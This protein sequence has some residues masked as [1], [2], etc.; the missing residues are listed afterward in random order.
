MI[1][2]TVILTRYSERIQ[3]II[4]GVETLSTIDPGM[5]NVTPV[6]QS[7]KNNDSSNDHDEKNGQGSKYDSEVHGV[8]MQLS[9]K[10]VRGS[11]NCMRLVASYIADAYLAVNKKANRLPKELFRFITNGV[12]L[13]MHPFHSRFR[14]LQK[15]YHI[16]LRLFVLLYC[17]QYHIYYKKQ[18]D[19]CSPFYIFK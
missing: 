10:R 4:F 7:D 2:S 12:R 19:T 17:L 16:C 13:Y 5:A 14:L 18:Y 3:I 15:Q 9:K 6:K 1:E 8:V 11:N